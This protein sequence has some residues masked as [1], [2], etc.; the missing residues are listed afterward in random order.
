M[1]SE[2]DLIKST[3]TFSQFRMQY[4]PLP[5]F[6]D[7][8]NSGK[9]WKRVFSCD[10]DISKVLPIIVGVILGLIIVFTVAGYFVAKRRSR[11]AYEELTQ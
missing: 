9:S 10:N 6:E 3:L 2:D 7:A 11:H 8:I 1:T 4:S 5:A